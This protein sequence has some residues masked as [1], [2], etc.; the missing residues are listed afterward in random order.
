MIKL[1]TRNFHTSSAS[2]AG[3]SKWANIRHT[4]AKTDGQKMA[5]FNKIAK[6]IAVSVKLGGSDPE[7]NT[8]LAA[9]LTNARHNNFPKDRIENALSGKSHDKT[10]LEDVT[11]EGYGPEGV[12][13]LIEALT[14]NRSRTSN[15]VKHLLSKHGGNMAAGAKYLFEHK[16]LITFEDQGKSE[17]E[18]MEVVAKTDAEDYHLGDNH[19]VEVM[20]KGTDF[21][22]VK[23]SIEQ[24]GFF[25]NSALFT[26]LP[27]Q[28]VK[29]SPESAE[30]MHLMLDAM[31][32]NEDIQKVYHNFEE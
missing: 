1:P 21:A 22:R 8:R 18:L 26:Y 6:E 2:F 16:G 27:T 25:C 30:Q 9:A 32:D 29:I 20:C 4:K 3:H 14:D 5:H 31:D 11:Y 12:A 13:I 7:Y 17:D 24:Q 23:K 19:H 28:K 10:H 15:S